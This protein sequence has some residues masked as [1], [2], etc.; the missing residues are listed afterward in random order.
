MEAAPKGHSK[1]GR[2]AAPLVWQEM[3]YCLSRW[4]AGIPQVLPGRGKCPCV[5]LFFPLP[6]PGGVGAA[7]HAG[8]GAVVAPL[9]FPPWIFPCFPRFPGLWWRDEAVGVLGMVGHHVGL[10]KGRAVDGELWEGGEQSSR[11][12]DSLMGRR[13]EGHPKNLGGPVPPPADQM[14]LCC[15]CG[16]IVPKSRSRISPEAGG[17]GRRVR[18]LSISRIP[19]LLL[20]WD[21]IS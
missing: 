9:V 19:K 18:D 10:L 17:M 14:S 1:S 15:P 13:G 6:S 3:G 11:S 12:W 4:P 16:G 2:K 8:G 21:L 7:A 5:S 20:C